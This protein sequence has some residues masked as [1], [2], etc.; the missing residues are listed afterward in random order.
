MSKVALI[1][2][3][4][5]PYVKNIDILENIYRERFSNIYHLIPFYNGEKTNVIPVYESS[6]YFQGYISQGY[7]SFFNEEYD[8]YFFIADD[9]LLN[10]IINE[11][12]YTKHLRLQQD[13]CFLPGFINLH[14]T[15]KYWPRVG[16]AFRYN[17]CAPGV[18][19]KNLLPAHDSALHA[20]K[21]HGL[22][23]KPLHFK[24]IWEPP[25]SIIDLARMIVKERF[26]II[27]FITNIFKKKL[28]NLKYP[29]VGGY[30]DIFVINA[31]T[32]RQ[33]CFFCGVTATTRLFVEVGL[34][35]SLVLSAK[36]I[37]TE[38]ELNLKGETDWTPEK[39][40][41][42]NKYKNSLSKLL[43]DFPDGYLYLHPIKLSKWNTIL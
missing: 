41:M 33:F 17:I 16:E 37:V 31:D 6:H 29:L 21:N 12:N 15:K 40:K 27:A 22:E 10:P 28:Y 1:F 3:Y 4:N 20:F 5:Y 7:R 9:L 35:T 24:Q 2:I 32:L 23:L 18:E 34:P 8:H 14:E 11:N 43:N 36:K 39:L 19:A 38:K 13:Y 25:R 42:L 30:S 26:S